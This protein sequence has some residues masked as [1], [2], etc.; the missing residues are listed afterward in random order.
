MCI[1]KQKLLGEEK[2]NSGQDQ[3]G[4]GWKEQILLFNKLSEEA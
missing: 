4:S 1:V 3:Y 2:E